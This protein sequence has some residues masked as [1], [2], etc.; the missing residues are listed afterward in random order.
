MKEQGIVLDGFVKGLRP[1]DEMPRNQEVLTECF[2]VIPR[3]QGLI[4]TPAITQSITAV[5]ASHPFPQ[6]F[7]GYI[8][9]L[10]CTE[11]KIYTINSDWSLTEQLDIST[12]YGAYPNAPKGTWHFADF[13]DYVILT[14]GG[15]N[16]IYDT[17]TSSWMYTSAATIPTLGSVLNFNGQII[18]TGRDT[19]TG[20]TQTVH[21]DAS[22]VDSNFLIWGGIGSATFRL[23]QSNV[24]GYRPMPWAGE[25]YKLMQLG[26]ITVAYGS[27]GIAFFE[28]VDVK[29]SLKH[30]LRYGIAS[31]EAVGGDESQHVAIDTEGNLRKF[32][33]ETIDP[34]PIYNEFFSGMIGNEIVVTYNSQQ[35]ESYITDGNSSY[36]LTRIGLAEVFQAP[37]TLALNAGTL[38]GFY[39]DLDDSEARITSDVLDYGVRGKKT[40]DTISVGCSAGDSVYVAV[41]Y[42]YEY[43]GAFVSTSWVEVNSEGVAFIT[44]TGVEFKFKIKCDDYSGFKLDY[45]TPKVKFDD[46]RFKRGINVSKTSA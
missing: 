35:K 23:D 18:G 38:V 44:I 25:I 14:N 30:F 34:E 45:F 7:L 10:C 9:W 37:T 12:Y 17:A 8:H 31:R 13:F 22:E 36:C 6:I 33:A 26:K 19:V 43:N 11:T 4:S 1:Y 29:P 42:K 20:D 2:N 46:K 41:E 5:S 24:A 32:T 28:F 3:P 39:T 16:V 15:V 40:I 21:P 27:N